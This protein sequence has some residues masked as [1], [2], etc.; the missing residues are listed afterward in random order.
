MKKTLAIL[1]FSTVSAL[2]QLPVGTVRNPVFTDSGGIVQN[3]PLTFSNFVSVGTI[4]ISN[5]VGTNL[6]ITSV[7]IFKGSTTVSNNLNVV[8]NIVAN[9][10]ASVYGI[11]T[12]SNATTIF[13]LTTVSNQVSSLTNNS[14]KYIVGG[15]DGWSGMI[16]NYGNGTTNIEMKSFGI[17]TNV[18]KNP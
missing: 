5:L 16:T 2:A 10:N 18:F 13:G 17:T 4:T 8:S 15:V 9:I 14:N 12:V 6:T 11:L 3:S 1:L 7:S